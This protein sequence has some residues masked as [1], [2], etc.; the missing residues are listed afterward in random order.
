[1]VAPAAR[2]AVVPVSLTLAQVAVLVLARDGRVAL[3][4]VARLA[5]GRVAGEAG[6]AAAEVGHALGASR[7]LAVVVAVVVVTVAT[8]VV[9]I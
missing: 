1:M 6:V 9:V 3:V 4:V 2:L 5:H 8:V 7:A